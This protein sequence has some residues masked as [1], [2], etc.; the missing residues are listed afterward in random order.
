MFWKFGFS[1]P[2]SID[3]LL[4][5][6]GV[7]LK[8]VL[9]NADVIQEC[10]NQNKLLVDFLKKPEHMAKLVDFVVTEPSDDVLDK[11]R[12]KYPNLAC[13]ILSSDIADIALAVSSEEN[14]NKIW[15]M[16]DRPPPLHPLLGSFFTRIV[17]ALLKSN[18]SVVNVLMQNPP[19]LDKLLKH[20]DNAAITDLLVSI[21]VVKP[22]GEVDVQKWLCE[23]QHLMERLSARFADKNSSKEVLYN[24]AQVLS[25]LVNFTRKELS[26]AAAEH[27]VDEDDKTEVKAVVYLNK[28]QSEEFMSA[29]LVNAL[30]G[31]EYATDY[32]LGVAISLLTERQRGE[33]EAPPTAEELQAH[34]TAVAGVLS[35]L[36]KHI[37]KL[38]ELLKV[39]PKGKS[40]VTSAGEVG[41]PLGGLRVKVAQVL[42]T[43][44][45]TGSEK[46]YAELASLKAVDTL[47]DLFFKYPDNNFFH[48]HVSELVCTAI[49]HSKP[50]QAPS[51]M[52]QS[53]F[54][55]GQL[56]GRLAQAWTDSDSDEAQSGKHRHGYMGF[57][58]FMA[59]AVVSLAGT[60]HEPF[61]SYLKGNEE[62]QNRWQ[63][64]LSEKIDPLN[65]LHA[66]VPGG[67]RPTAGGAASDDDDFFFTDT[68]ET[69]NAELAFAKFLNEKICDVPDDITLE[70]EPEDEDLVEQ[71]GVNGLFSPTVEINTDV[72]P[73]QVEQD[74]VIKDGPDGAADEEMG[75]EE[76][77][78]KKVIDETSVVKPRVSIVHS[79]SEDDDDN[80]SDSDGS[81]DLGQVK[82][83]DVALS[84]RSAQAVAGM[85][86]RDPF[87][88]PRKSKD[89]PGA[90]AQFDTPQ[91][92]D[93]KLS[94]EEYEKK[95]GGLMSE[96][97]VAINNHAELELADK[98]IAAEEAPSKPQRRLPK[99]PHVLSD[100]Q[101]LTE[102][103]ERLDAA[104]DA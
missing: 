54:V 44:A 66:T 73:M 67:V 87:V 95:L 57:I 34:H 91:A 10:K 88:S 23:D 33:D 52:L 61:Q 50:T 5:K 55:D 70:D 45:N 26:D 43:L 11:T 77:E 24:A 56:L 64:F 86:T 58:V 89:G 35:A 51:P 90:W 94:D 18:D 99:P 80:D 39:A 78:E 85:P 38:C 3:T 83:M 2:S 32:G 93:V 14:F 31:N 71:Y 53:L 17:S 69:T 60:P 30:S 103:Q 15:A 29:F 76:W 102:D 59:N 81:Y 46:V 1:T 100:S 98:D 92:M 4:N 96:H 49:E 6:E 47:L 36:Q 68:E 7:E 97:S 82:H 75:E 101:L 84:P 41:V 22:L 65:K 63:K 27:A 19:E 74:W 40:I 37:P 79:S 25:D 12:F 72:T 62:L 21:A 48:R 42:K 16:L 20:L 104:S 13:E 28:L 9:D 8:E